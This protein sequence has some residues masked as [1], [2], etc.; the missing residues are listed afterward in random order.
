MLNAAC[1]AQGDVQGELPNLCIAFPPKMKPLFQPFRYK[2]FYGGRAGARSWSFARALLI[3]GIQR[4]TRILCAREVQN[5][6]KDSVYKL[7]KD[8]IRGLGMLSAYRILDHE[9]R[10]VNGTEFTFVGLSVMTEESIK[11]YEGYDIVWVEEAKTVTESS[12]KILIPTIRKEDSEIWISF[13]PELST[14]YT[15]QYFVLNPPPGAVVV[16]VNYKDN[17][18]FPAVLEAERLHCLK[19]DPDGYA[20]IWGGECKPAVEGA[21]YYKQLLAADNNK[22]ICRLP[23]DP[24]LKVHVVI[25]LGFGHNMSVGC[26]QKHASELRVIDY[27]QVQGYDLNDISLE[28]RKRPYNWGRFWLPHDGFS[29]DHKEKKTSQSILQALSWDTPDRSEIVEMSIE[30]GIRLVQLT[31]PQVLFDAERCG[32][33]VDNRKEGGLLY[34]GLLECL[35]R[36]HRRRDIKTGTFTTPAQDQFTDGADFFRYVCQN[37]PSFINV[38][39]TDQWQAAA[40]DKYDEANVDKSTGY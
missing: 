30:E 16:K 18:W 31:F 37:S 2:V 36:Y 35:R 39:L 7:L 38:D 28:L 22:Q 32:P 20:N 23:Y 33:V 29:Q 24:Y 1:S 13:N 3:R 8:Q 6:I 34:G 11:S 19:N 15:Y 10:G 17:P 25:D 4:P 21:I 9:I 14:D 27:F 12:W 5:S 26:I 40:T